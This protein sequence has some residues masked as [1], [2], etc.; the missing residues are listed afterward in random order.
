MKRMSLPRH[1]K[2][3]VTLLSA[4]IMLMA[5]SVNVFAAGSAENI[6]V[7]HELAYADSPTDNPLKGFATIND[8]SWC[9]PTSLE[10]YQLPLNEMVFGPDDFDWTHLE[11]LLSATASRGRTAIVS[12]YMDWPGRETAIPKYLLDAGLKTHYYT[13]WGG[14]YSADYQDERIWTMVYNFIRDFGAKYDGDTRIA[15]IYTSL[16]GYWGEHHTYPETENGPSNEQLVKLAQAYDAAFDVT[17]LSMRYPQSALKDVNIGYTDFSFAYESVNV[18]WSTYNYLLWSDATTVWEDNMCGG[19]LYPQLQ[20]EIFSSDVWVGGNGDEYTDCVQKLHPSFL[21]NAVCAWNYKGT[22]LE[23]AMEAARMLGYDFSAESASFKDNVNAGDN[24]T[25]SVDIRNIGVAPF[26]YNWDINIG[27]F[28][29]G[30]LVSTYGTDWDIT[31]IQA[32]GRTH[33][34]SYDIGTVPAGDYTLAIKV[35]NPQPGGK[36]LRFANAAQ[37]DDGWLVLGEFSASPVRLAQDSLAGPI[38]AD[39]SLY[40]R[41][42]NFSRR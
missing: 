33:T 39:E 31:A 2:L 21:L 37:R 11:N 1:M 32:D 38:P 34:F 27:L 12:F 40:L 19:E 16:I 13:S 25:L 24:Q 30:A 26:Y 18:D 28:K 8:E 29:N 5:G 3:I 36:Q 35:V 42:P 6:A 20:R 22:T 23:N 41:W 17:Q 4:V 7:L 9:M 15:H 14:G 10:Y